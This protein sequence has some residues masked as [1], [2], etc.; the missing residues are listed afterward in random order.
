L[1]IVY[2]LL[3]HGDTYHDLTPTYLDDRRRARLQQ[4]AIDQLNALGYQVSLTP[5]PSAA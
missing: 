1:T 2:A 3:L 4:R 5:N